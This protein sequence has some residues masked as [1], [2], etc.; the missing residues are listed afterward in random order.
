MRIILFTGKGGV[1][2][3]TVAVATAL[4][5]ADLGHRVLTMSTDPAHSLGD[6]LSTPLTGTPSVVAPGLEA[7]EIDALAE[8]D[9]AWAGLRTYLGRL[10]TRGGEV[11]LA[12]EEALLLPGLGE[13]FALLRILDHASSDQHDVLVVD[14]APTGE[15]MSLLKYPERLDQLIK[16]ALPTKRAL[17]RLL[18]RPFERLTRIPMPEDRLFDD[19]LN[20]TGRLKQ[21]GELLHDGRSTT[22]RLVTTPEHV[23]VEET[24][25]AHTWLTMYGFLVDGVVLNRIHPEAALSG[26]FARWA[27][28]QAAG[29]QRVAE[30]FGHLPI[31]RLP[32]QE[33]EVVGM[34]ALRSLARQLYGDDDP[35]VV[36]HRG[37]HMRVTRSDGVLRL[38][39]SLP[40]AVRDELELQ[41]DGGDLLLSHRGQHRRIALPDSLTGRE[42][43]AAR[44]DGGE[45]VLT[46]G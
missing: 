12:T 23:V 5:L 18:G 14:C 6:A 22:L 45:L 25:R 4:H 13:L 32:L 1:G 40:H 34:A 20:L 16:T 44:F 30:S 11:S 41:Q 7:M 29:V 15:T 39:L 27:E 8:N 9:K 38:H 28:H 19:L 42:V 21:L 31:H 37:E 3:T 36:Q 46:M 26:Y 24:R 43:V 33:R 10:L 2:K 35:S 17:V